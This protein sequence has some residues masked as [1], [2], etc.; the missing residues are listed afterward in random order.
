LGKYVYSSGN[1]ELGIHQYFSS[2]L[3]DETIKLNDGSEVKISLNLISGFPFEGKIYL[4][5]SDLSTARAS[6]TAPLNIVV[7]QP[8]WTTGMTV[9][10]NGV[11]KISRASVPLAQSDAA[12]GFDPRT[13][14][15]HTLHRNWVA[16]DEIVIEFE[17]PILTRRAHPKV[18][19]HQGKVA[20]TRGPLVYCLE[21]VDQTKVDIFNTAVDINSLHPVT[22]Q[23]SL[24]KIVQL[25]GNS[26]D[27]QPVT[28]IPYFL[29]GNRGPSQ[30][31]VWMNE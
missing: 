10:I 2:E 6:M 30:M 8:S 18:K 27:G 5:I 28:L 20:I 14:R 13:A 1:G 3:Q 29:W 21:N 16:G 23:T 25:C 9:T 31:T 24:G 17:M 15:F 22:T 11:P 26:K 19:G 7:R 12:S 4:K